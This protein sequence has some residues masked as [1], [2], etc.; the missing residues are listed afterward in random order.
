MPAA[1]KIPKMDKLSGCPSKKGVST[2]G[3]QDLKLYIYSRTYSN[4]RL[5]KT[6]SPFFFFPD[7]NL[8]KAAITNQLPLL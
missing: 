1:A 2:E 8:L 6:R 7:C 3:G 5:L 4:T